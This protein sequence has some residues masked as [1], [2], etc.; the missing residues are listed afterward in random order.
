MGIPVG[1]GTIGTA[2]A[3][4]EGEGRGGGRADKI[5]VSSPE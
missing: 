2:L 3:P 1:G 4:V 5:T